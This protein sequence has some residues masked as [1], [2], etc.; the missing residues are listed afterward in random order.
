MY[1]FEESFDPNLTD[2]YP[3]QCMCYADKYMEMHLA[4]SRHIKTWD[5]RTGLIKRVNKSNYL[6][7]SI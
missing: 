2:E 4:T 5:V 1:Q 6:K 3:I 7:D